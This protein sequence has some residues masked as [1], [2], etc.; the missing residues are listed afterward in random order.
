[1][2]AGFG[3]C[4]CCQKR[5]EKKAI[6]LNLEMLQS[7]EQ[8][9]SA[10]RIPLA[11]LQHTTQA[12]TIQKCYR[13]YAVRK[14][15][16]SKTRATPGPSIQSTPEVRLSSARF[17]VPVL[18]DFSNPEARATE[19]RLG[20]FQDPG[21]PSGLPTGLVRKGPYQVENGAIYIGEW[22]SQGRR[23]GQGL[24]VWTDGSKY[25]GYW[26]NDMAHGPGRLIHLNGDVYEG[27]WANDKS[28]GKGRYWHIDGSE[29]IGGWEDDKQ[30]GQ[31]TECWP[32]GARYDGSYERGMKHGKGRFHW[33]DA[34]MYEGDFVNSNIQGYGVYT[35][36]DGRRYEGEWMA[37]KMHGKGTFTWNDGRRYVGMYVNDKKQGYGE[38]VWRDGRKYLG[39]W[40]EG[41]QHGIATYITPDGTAREGEWK[42]GKRVRWLD[43]NN[44][45]A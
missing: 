42:D 5:E 41:K 15:R 45:N 7:P 27:E 6:V 1:M 4:E 22:D 33:S 39:Q 17:P 11:K 35:W 9:V 23:C 36:N 34:S 26:L 10:V 31:G 18:P 43:S 38:F 28:H 25:E 44:K 40:L 2:G 14:K 30:H 13:G 8:P 20:P 16:G 3:G 32:D 29:Y 21:R 12:L 37:N 19:Q 24:Q